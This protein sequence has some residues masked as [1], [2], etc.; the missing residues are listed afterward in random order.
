MQDAELFAKRPSDNEQRFDQRR[1]VGQVLDKLPDSGLEPHRPNHANL[2]A[3]VA[4]STAQ[5]VIDSDRLRLQQLAVG[6]QH[7]QFLAA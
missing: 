2:E 7:P 1:Q 4:Q 3:E 6:Q 5:V